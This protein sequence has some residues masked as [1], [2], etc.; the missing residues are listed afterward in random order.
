[1]I[2][3]LLLVTVMFV[4]AVLLCLAAM[5]WRIS[6]PG[7]P[8]LHLANI[9]EGTHGGG[10]F[11]K[12][13]DAAIARYRLCK[14]G[15][16][17]DHVVYAGAGEQALFVATDEAGAA[18]DLIGVQA[19]ALSGGT[20]KMVTNGAGVLAAGDLLVAAANGKVAKKA[21][22]AGNYYV[23]G[24]A[25]QAAAATDGDELEVIPI[26]SVWTNA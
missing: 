13:A 24:V 19:L 3:S 1:M 7:G 12:K 26:G 16:D 8:S 14:F 4:A 9:A 6:R 5:L 22:G 20:V 23:V 10:A 11:S 17:A 2:P 25:A 15:S 21:A 18:E